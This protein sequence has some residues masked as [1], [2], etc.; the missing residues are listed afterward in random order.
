MNFELSEELVN[1]IHL[2]SNKLIIDKD[3]LAILKELG[4]E[5]F[6]GSIHIKEIFTQDLNDICTA[7]A[8]TSYKTKQYNVKLTR[9][10]LGNEIASRWFLGETPNLFIL[11]DCLYKEFFTFIINNPQKRCWGKI[12][13]I[14]NE[15]T[16]LLKKDF[17][18]WEEK[19]L[20]FLFD[21]GYN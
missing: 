16:L 14:F 10:I 3:V 7:L 4:Y 18:F 13:I 1:L 12:C 20:D 15:I 21:T 5:S 8:K 19:S 11:F 6:E 9:E 17:A 2:C